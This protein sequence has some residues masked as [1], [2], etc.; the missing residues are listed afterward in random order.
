MDTAAPP[1]VVPYDD[2]EAPEFG[3]ELYQ[4][5]RLESLEAKHDQHRAMAADIRKLYG[6]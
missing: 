3:D 2:D 4:P 5:T 6:F 1:T